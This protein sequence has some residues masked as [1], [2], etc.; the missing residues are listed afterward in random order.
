MFVY[1]LASGG[2]VVNLLVPAWCARSAVDEGF[3]ARAVQ[4][5][6]GKESQG[7]QAAGETKPRC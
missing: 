6:N 3:S 4:L 7:P 1:L 2:G 5:P